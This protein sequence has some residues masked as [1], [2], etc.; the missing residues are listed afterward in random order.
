MLD[1]ERR[2]I[3]TKGD[4]RQAMALPHPEDGHY[5]ENLRKLCIDAD[6]SS[7]V[8]MPC[9]PVDWFNTNRFEL[10]QDTKRLKLEWL[11]RRKHIPEPV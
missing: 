5:I 1:W 7:R 11:K 9:L 4:S 6:G 2:L 8:S 10:R 3:A